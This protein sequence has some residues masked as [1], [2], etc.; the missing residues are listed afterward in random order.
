MV[1]RIFSLTEGIP[2]ALETEIFS[3]TDTF[4]RT[5]QPEEA[6][7]F[8]YPTHY[9]VAYDYAAPDF[10]QHGVNVDVQPLIRQRFAELDALSDR[11]GKKIIA[12]YIRDNAQPLPAPHAIVFRTSLTASGRQRNEFA[13]PANGRPLLT[14]KTDLPAY[15][16]WSPIPSVGFRGQAAPM[17]L[18]FGL[19]IRNRFNLFAEQWGWKK[20]FSFRYNF[21]YLHRRNAL[22][23]LQQAAGIVLDYRITTTA[24]IFAA[25]SRRAYVESLLRN[26]YSLCVS[27][28][29]NYSSRLYETMAAGRI[30]LFVNTD[31]VLPLE[32]MIDY[33]GMFV[34]V[35]ADALHRIAQVLRHYHTIHEGP[36]LLKKQQQIQQV[37]HQY[38]EASQFFR[39]IPFYLRHFKS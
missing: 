30:P 32:E 16:E 27:G 2:E 28:H 10:A 19:A 4:T 35:E 36:S 34:W 24:D 18:P 33:K 37:W 20:P 23:Y 22:Y 17:Q 31:C 38:F 11:Y 3:C 14:D 21:G 1:Y 39:Y 25:N 13:F 29:G 8:A 15:I 6:D 9:Q 12:V 5:N 26:P 7:F